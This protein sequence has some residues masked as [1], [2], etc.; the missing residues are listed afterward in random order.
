VLSCEASLRHQA[1]V[2]HLLAEAADKENDAIFVD[3][4]DDSDK[5]VAGGAPDAGRTD[6]SV[7]RKRELL[8]TEAT[9]DSSCDVG[10]PATSA[11]RTFKEAL[12]GSQPSIG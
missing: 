9:L 3:P 6:V 8:S 11:P 1:I 2:K 12:I 10:K 5:D 7:G 4:S